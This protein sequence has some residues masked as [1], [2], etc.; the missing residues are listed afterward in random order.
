MPP[1]KGVWLHDQEGSAA[2]F[3]PT[4]PAGRGARDPF[5]CSGP[6]HLA[7]EDDELLS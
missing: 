3:E 7:P 2:R 5:S 4:W 1:E 6:F